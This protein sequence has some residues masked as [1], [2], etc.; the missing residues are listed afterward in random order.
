MTKTDHLRQVKYC[1][2]SIVF[3]CPFALCQIYS[4]EHSS[5]AQNGNHSCLLDSN[6]H[7]W[8]PLTFNRRLV[9]LAPN[10]QQKA[11]RIAR[12]SAANGNMHRMSTHM[13]PPRSTRRG[14]SSQ[15]KAQAWETK[16]EQM[17]K[18]YRVTKKAGNQSPASSCVTTRPSLAQLNGYYLAPR[19]F[20]CRHRLT[21]RLKLNARNAIYGLSR[22]KY[23]VAT[24]L[25]TDNQSIISNANNIAMCSTCISGKAKLLASLMQHDTK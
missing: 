18:C 4:E 25:S 12:L 15:Q 23:P 19:R 11:H 1:L 3:E 5:H 24:T 6:L 20:R 13:K 7:G 16:T 21:C 10:L 8:E 17:I 2:Q 22:Q 9:A 14:C